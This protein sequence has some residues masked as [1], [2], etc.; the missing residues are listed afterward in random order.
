MTGDPVPVDLDV[1]TTQVIERLAP[2][3]EVTSRKMFG[4]VGFFLEG[5]MFAKLTGRG[6]L[7]FRV[8]DSNRG[9]YEAHGTDAF[10]S[11]D[12]KKSMPY[13]EVPKAVVEDDEAFIEWAR[14]AH[15]VAVVHKR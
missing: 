7:Y 6:L 2:L 8:D 12:K 3:G 9:A 1:L 15:G 11:V 4:G 13:Y 5:V 14:V 10:H